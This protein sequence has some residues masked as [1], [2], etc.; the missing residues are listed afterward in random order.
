[1]PALAGSLLLAAACRGETQPPP[2]ASGPPPTPPVAPRAPSAPPLDASAGP[3]PSTP[4]PLDARASSGGATAVVATAP[5][6]TAAVAPARARVGERC[7]GL[8][9]AS[10][11][12]AIFVTI[13]VKN[14][15][16][17]VLAVA[18]PRPGGGSL[19]LRLT[20]PGGN[21]QVATV[22]QRVG[23]ARPQL[24]TLQ[25][26]PGDRTDIELE[27]GRYVPLEVPGAYKLVL[28]YAWRPGEVWRSPELGFALDPR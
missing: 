22:E 11:C 3:P 18:D 14:P 19:V 15:S 2:S 10:M 23:G 1:M 25:V 9:V 28:E 20:P 4:S 8:G 17:E 24:V 6:F 12:R 27:L 21:E 16:R 26:P 7:S 5:V 13:T